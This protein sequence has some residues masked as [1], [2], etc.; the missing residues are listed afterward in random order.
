MESFVFQPPL[1]YSQVPIGS[2]GT[3]QMPFFNQNISKILLFTSVAVVT[4]FSTLALA[5]PNPDQAVLDAKAVYNL[6][7]S[8]GNLAQ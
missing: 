6:N 8:A 5:A 7:P 4:T 2:G 1:V 3:I